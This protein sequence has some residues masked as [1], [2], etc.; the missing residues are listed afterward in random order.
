M[1]M[2]VVED[3]MNLEKIKKALAITFV[4][5]PCLFFILILIALSI[6]DPTQAFILSCSIGLLIGLVWGGVYLL[7]R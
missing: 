5:I 2:T 1:R 7:D 3:N 6:K 4:T